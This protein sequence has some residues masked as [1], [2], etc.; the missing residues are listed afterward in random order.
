MRAPSERATINVLNRFDQSKTAGVTFV[1]M[2]EHEF[3]GIVY[4]TNARQLFANLYVYGY[5][6]DKLPVDYV[7]LS[8]A[9]M[10]EL[11]FGA[12]AAAVPFDGD[13][14][15]ELKGA[16]PQMTAP[17]SGAGALVSTVGLTVVVLVRAA[18][19]AVW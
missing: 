6:R 9:E 3:R 15:I 11:D 4:D 17:S 19:F 16:R 7:P 2:T 18:A 1:L 14:R 8:A 13:E 10:P 12:A 5:K